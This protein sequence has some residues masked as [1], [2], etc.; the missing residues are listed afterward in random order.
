MHIEVL[1]TGQLY[2][3][4]LSTSVFT[5][6]CLEACFPC[7]A[8][9]SCP[10]CKHL[11]QSTASVNV[12]AAESAPLLGKNLCPPYHHCH[13]H[14]AIPHT[15]CDAISCRKL[16]ASASCCQCRRQATPAASSQQCG[17]RRG[18]TASRGR[19]PWTTARCCAAMRASALISHPTHSSSSA[20]LLGRHSW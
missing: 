1:R 15:T 10:R 2:A 7:S 11:L 9:E 14:H 12:Q 4:V 5:C 3:A 20:A 18:P 17:W 13:H 8:H 16:Q 19:A 6:L